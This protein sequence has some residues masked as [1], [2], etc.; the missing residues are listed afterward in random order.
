VISPEDI[1]IDDTGL[2]ASV[3]DVDM[4]MDVNVDSSLGGTDR[5][6]SRCKLERPPEA[7]AKP[8][9]K[10]GQY[11]YCSHCRA[12]S[13]QHTTETRKRKREQSSN[14]MGGVIVGFGIGDGN[15]AHSTVNSNDGLNSRRIFIHTLEEFVQRFPTSEDHFET[16]AGN[17]SNGKNDNDDNHNSD[18]NAPTV[19][20]NF[21]LSSDLS[22]D[23]GQT[24]IAD[25]LRGVESEPVA[26]FKKIVQIIYETTGFFFSR[27]ARSKTGKSFR[28]QYVCSQ[29]ADTSNTREVRE[30][31]KRA[32][33]RRQL[34]DCHGRLIIS[35]S[36]SDLTV[37]VKYSH[38]LVHGSVVR[39][40]YLSDAAKQFIFENRHKPLSTIFNGI[41]ERY[42]LDPSN[43]DF[44]I[45]QITRK[46]VYIYVRRLEST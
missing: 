7:F 30:A 34:F 37:S 14:N 9:G 39:R 36:I 6:C 3:D 19:S 21:I 26:L 43:P 2:S 35:A 44:D 27:R 13:R 42:L 40:R 41:K 33:T 46:Q 10:P 18:I 45:S 31:P 5:T 20:A 24:T 16:L 28:T 12:L 32:R 25:E 4:D 29:V 8:I 23:G 38:K 22:M 11:K 17:D 1:R 15:D